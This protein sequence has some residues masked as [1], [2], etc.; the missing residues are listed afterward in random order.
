V[1]TLIIGFLAR[2]VRWV[3]TLSV[4]PFD[5][6][7]LSTDIRHEML[8]LKNLSARPCSSPGLR[9]GRDGEK[10]VPAG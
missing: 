8:R 6:F 4:R 10:V 2:S 9:I 5:S 3:A 1:Y 7:S